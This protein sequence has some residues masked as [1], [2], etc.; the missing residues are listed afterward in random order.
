M[1]GTT[2]V[3]G[4]VGVEG[5]TMIG[6]AM[7]G[8]EPAIGLGPAKVLPVLALESSAPIGL[9]DEITGL[10]KVVIG[11]G[12][13]VTGVGNVVTGVGNEVTG[14]VGEPKRLGGC[15]TAPGGVV[16]T[17]GGVP[18]TPAGVAPAGERIWATAGRAAIAAAIPTMVDARMD[19]SW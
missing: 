8:V 10:G 19:I 14:L 9:G 15:P 6:A 4:R 12:K 11:A 16:M 13:V 7:L 5:D 2:G 3:E 1:D 18:D 17:L